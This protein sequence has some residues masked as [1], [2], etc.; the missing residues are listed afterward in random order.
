MD[1]RYSANR[2]YDGTRASDARKD[3][4]EG[5]ARTYLARARRALSDAQ[6]YGGSTGGA[7]SSDGGGGL[8]ALLN[9]NQ[10]IK[11]ERKTFRE[12]GSGALGARASLAEARGFR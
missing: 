12:Q 6:S 7:Q 11:E 9:R 4:A 3:R 1:R 2:F 10:V 5:L 8:N